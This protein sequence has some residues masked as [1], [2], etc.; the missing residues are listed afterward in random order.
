MFSIR[1]L[2]NNNLHTITS[3]TFYGLKDLQILNLHSNQLTCIEN[4]TFID[5]TQLK[6]L[7]LNNNRI[8]YL[9]SSFDQLRFL[10][11]L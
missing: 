4:D 6:I 10:S 8:K 11:N 2:N 3:D 5:M 9:S 1:F 7:T